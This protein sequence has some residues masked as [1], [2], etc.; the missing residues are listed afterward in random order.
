M[1][2]VLARCRVAAQVLECVP[3]FFEAEGDVQVGV[4]LALVVVVLLVRGR[5]N[6]PLFELFEEDLVGAGEVANDFL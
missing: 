3:D 1:N 5:I 4:W 6:V 2:A